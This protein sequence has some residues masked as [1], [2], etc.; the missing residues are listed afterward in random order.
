M[1]LYEKIFQKLQKSFSEDNS[2]I[3]LIDTKGDGYHF[4]LTIISP[5][6]EAKSRLQ[7]SQMVYKILDQELKSGEIHAITMTLQTPEEL[8]N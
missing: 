3:T 1:D 2:K 4:E 6:F 5:E 8:E 7:R